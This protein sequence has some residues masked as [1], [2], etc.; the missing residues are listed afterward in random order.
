M[1]NENTN[2]DFSSVLASTIH[3]IKNSL[4]ILLGTLSDVT[5]EIECTDSIV[6]NK[7]KQMRLEGQ[8]V[9]RDLIQLLVLYRLNKN[10]YYIN[11]QEYNLA[12]FIDDLVQDNQDIFD[13]KDIRLVVECDPLIQ[14]Y[15]DRELIFGVINSTI[16][17]AYKYTKDLIKI[18]CET[19]GRGISISVEDNGPGYP[20]K[21]LDRE[22]SELSG[23]SFE[24]GNTG[25][26][27]YFAAQIAKLH[28]SNGESGYTK[29]SNSGPDNGG[30]F[31]IVI[32]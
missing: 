29:L 25:L 4:G 15:F 24:T 26:G 32:P 27:M 31:T 16:H 23:F 8:R 21:L 28:Q 1:T 11:A 14:G 9:N 12:D 7:L 5:E 20:A 22:S 10:E 6:S 13:F 30:K 3:D 17:N 18:S 2:L 19:V